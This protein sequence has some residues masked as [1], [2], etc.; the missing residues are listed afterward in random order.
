LILSFWA[1]LKSFKILVSPESCLEAKTENLLSFIVCCLIK[2]SLLELKTEFMQKQKL[3][4]VPVVHTCN[5]SYSGG[6]DQEDHCLKPARQ[7]VPQDPI[8]K[9]PITKR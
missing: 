2:K 5:P 1:V 8:S 9:K 4:W 3:S 6:R 7:I